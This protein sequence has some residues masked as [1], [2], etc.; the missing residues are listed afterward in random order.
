MR[1]FIVTILCNAGGYD[2][3]YRAEIL[4]FNGSSWNKIGMLQ[5]GRA[6]AAA[7]KMNIDI[8]GMC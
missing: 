7:T 1:V 4:S 2:G 6:W 8:T 3:H 5:K